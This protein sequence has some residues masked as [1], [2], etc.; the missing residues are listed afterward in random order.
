[1]TRTLQARQPRSTHALFGTGPAPSTTRD[2]L[3]ES[4]L[5][6]FYTHGFH[7]VGLDQVLADVGIS[8]Q[9]FYKHFPSKDDLAVEAIKLRDQRES[10][11]F[12]RAVQKHAGPA[13]G[14]R[15]TLLAMFDALDE[16]FTAP[17]YHGCLFLTACFE[18]PSPTDPLHRAAGDH[19]AAAEAMIRELADSAGADDPGELASELVQLLQGAFTRRVVAGDNLAAQRARR[20]AE[21]VLQ[22]A[23]EPNE[24]P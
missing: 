5:D 18:F 7:A 10:E 23:I 6:L 1:M 12:L 13:A 24:H 14:V 9:A 20:L 17:D 2:K 3:I 22:S 19:Y 11:A 16:W 21:L 15:R 8:K 4:A